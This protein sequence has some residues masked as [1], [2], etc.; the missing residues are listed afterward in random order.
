MAERPRLPRSKPPTELPLDDGARE[1][2]D[3]WREIRGVAFCHWDRWLLRL[4]LDDAGGLPAIARMF[5]GRAT[6]RVR[7]DHVAGP[8]LA[9]IADLEARLAHLGLTG[10]AVLDD[11][12]RA[13][14]WLH[15][16]ASRRVLQATSI[17]CTPAMQRTPRRLLED[18]ALRGNWAAFPV[19]PS[20]YAQELASV[21]GQ[22]QYDYRGTGLIVFLL[23]HAGERMLRAANDDLERLAIHRAMLT[24]V[25]G[26]MEQVDDSGCEMGEHFRAHER[27]YL[28]QVRPRLGTPG[29]L[30]DLLELVV[31]EDYGLFAEV[32]AFVASLPE[33]EADLATRELARIIA[34]LR[35]AGLDYQLERARSLRKS[36]LLAGD[37]LLAQE[38]EGEE[39]AT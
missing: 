10:A 12:E 21:P 2:T 23:D 17:R 20:L 13:S 11:E 34:E 30:R 32:R 16:K 15:A 22:G 5:R 35:T 9:Q 38:G 31:W 4:S 25:I 37:T 18:R 19:S 14:R 27:A 26:A 39:A 6:A 28:A 33:P 1:G 29:L 7:S 36:L 24:V 8:M 3:P